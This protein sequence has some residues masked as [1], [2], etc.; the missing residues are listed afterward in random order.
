MERVEIIDKKENGDR[1]KVTVSAWEN[2]MKIHYDISVDESPKGRRKWFPVVDT[3]D[4]F[5]RRL[6]MTERREYC[7]KKNL[8]VAGSEIINKA[9][10]KC[11]ESMKPELYKDCEEL[12]K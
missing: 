10:L 7:E 5:Y 3:D 1:I 11:W 4:Y 8:E 9:L 6:G 12:K 2:S